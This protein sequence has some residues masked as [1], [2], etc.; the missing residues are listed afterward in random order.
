[1]ASVGKDETLAHGRCSCKLVHLTVI[2]KYHVTQDLLKESASQIVIEVFAL[3]CS[4]QH[5]L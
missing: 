5:C 4:R 1:M 3:A 2:M